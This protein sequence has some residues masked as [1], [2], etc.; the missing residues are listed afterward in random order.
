MSSNPTTRILIADDDAI[1][2]ELV[3]L[4]LHQEGFQVL[5]AKTGEEALSLAMRRQPDLCILDVM[6]PGTDGYTVCRHLRTNESTRLM[7]ILILTAQA[8]ARDKLAGFEAGADD[9][10]TKP[11]DPAELVLRVKALL[12]RSQMS[13]ISANKNVRRGKIWTVFGAK[14][15]VGK[16][17]T[18]VNLA[19]ALAREPNTSIALVDADFSFGDLSAHLNLAPSRTILDLLPYLDE[20]DEELLAKVM[21]RHESNVRVLLGPYRPQDAE[22]VTPEALQ[23]IL[24]ALIEY[25]DYVLVDCACSYDD[26]TLAL[27]DNADLILMLL[28]PEIGPVKNASTFLELANELEISPSKIQLILN[29]ANSEVGIA[30]AEIERALQ[31]AIPMRL[32]SGGRPVVMSVNRGVPMLLEQPQHPFSQQITR[33]ANQLK[34]PVLASVR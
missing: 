11:F 17:M 10:L 23:H 24:Q 18:A 21:I 20:L 4:V 31:K 12:A 34:A 15:G 27:L 6:M 22:R 26:R 14:G 1:I 8:E 2:R 13:K 28:T 16:T 25:F 5:P 30:A 3:G 7:P 33:F 9:Y 29:R 32:I 19:I